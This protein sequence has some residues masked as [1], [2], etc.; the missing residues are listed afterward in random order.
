MGA[1]ILR[2]SGGSPRARSLLAAAALLALPAAVRLGEYRALS[3][4]ADLPA[5]DGRPTLLFLFQPDDCRAY[6][7]LVRRWNSLASDSSL[8]VLG[9]GLR[10]GRP[11]PGDSV[12]GEPKPRFSVRYDLTGPGQRLLAR[13]GW[14]E[15]PTSVLLDGRGRPR[16]IVP[17]I[18]DGNAQRDALLLV[19]AWARRFSERRGAEPGPG[20]L[21][22]YPERR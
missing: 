2:L 20:A 6:G 11:V 1:P 4:P 18:T 10:F 14:L 8:R 15:T 21:N 19:R 9:L 22:A 5:G 12:L 17:P 16:L 13:L 3:A 7:G